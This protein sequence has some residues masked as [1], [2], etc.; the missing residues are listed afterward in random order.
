MFLRDHAGVEV[1][2][3]KSKNGRMHLLSILKE[4][5]RREILSVLLEAGS[6]L[7]GAA[8][9]AGVVNR[10]FLFYAPKIVGENRAPFALAP[11]LTPQLLQNV[12]IH[13]F[14]PDFALEARLNDNFP[15]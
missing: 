10:L 2:R 3:A 13:Q 4:L 1:V 12:Q 14:G 11:K 8:L 6:T 5:G 9:T 15:R 7:N